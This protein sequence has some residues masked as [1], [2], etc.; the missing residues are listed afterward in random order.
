MPPRPPRPPG[1]PGLQELHSGHRETFHIIVTA[2]SAS[3]AA[4]PTLSDFNTTA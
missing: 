1:P 3:Q 4:N 2:A